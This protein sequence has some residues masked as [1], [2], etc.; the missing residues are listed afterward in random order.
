MPKKRTPEPPAPEPE[1]R[2]PP[3]MAANQINDRIAKGR[4]IH[5]REVRTE[6]D[7]EEC[8]KEYRTWTA[9]NAELLK[10]L[11]TSDKYQEEYDWWG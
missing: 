5:K 1:L 9:Y 10:R 6:P 4:S 11:F 3:E 7:L 2:V 8:E